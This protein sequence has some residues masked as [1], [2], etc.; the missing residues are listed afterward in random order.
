MCSGCERKEISHTQDVLV[1]LKASDYHEKPRKCHLADLEVW[2]WSKPLMKEENVGGSKRRH[3]PH[4]PAHVARPWPQLPQVQPTHEGG[5]VIRAAAWMEASY[6]LKRLFTRERRKQQW[7][8]RWPSCH[9]CGN[10]AP[11]TCRKRLCLTQKGI[12]FR[13]C[14]LGLWVP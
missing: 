11:Q 9:T 1:L 7:R 4:Q 10:I 6:P 14:Q 2:N 3:D 5:A 13:M 8:S 12:W